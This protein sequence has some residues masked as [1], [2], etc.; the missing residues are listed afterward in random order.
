MDVGLACVDREAR[1]LHYAGAKISLYWSDGQTVQE[2][3]GGR[4][5]LGDRRQGSYTDIQ[6]EIVPGATY[7]L[8]TDGFLDQ[9]GGEL[10]YGFGDTRFAQLLL[11]HARLPMEQQASALNQVL[12]AYRGDYPQRD[13]ITLLSFRIA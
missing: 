12:E 13:D 11:A 1:T 7:Y 5:A 6:V 3:K 8:T 9:A 10:G 4:R 2:V